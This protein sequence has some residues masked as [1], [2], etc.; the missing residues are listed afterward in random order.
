MTMKPAVLLM[1]QEAKEYLPLFH[2][3]IA[4]TFGWVLIRGEN[5]L[6]AEWE[7]GTLLG[8]YSS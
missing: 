4:F 1:R 3:E 7:K 6:Y 2:S 8:L 5:F